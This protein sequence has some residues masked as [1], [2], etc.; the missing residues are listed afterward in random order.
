MSETN[1]YSA[2][3]IRE[4]NEHFWP[5]FW[6]TPIAPP[7]AAALTRCLPEATGRMTATGVINR[8]HWSGIAG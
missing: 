2:I 3:R 5:A 8:C 1:V 4:R 7:A 6:H